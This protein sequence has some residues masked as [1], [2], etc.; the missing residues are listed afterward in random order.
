MLTDKKIMLKN[1][2]YKFLVQINILL[3]IMKMGCSEFDYHTGVNFKL[4]SK[5][6][7]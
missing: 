3:A 2:Y 1:N 6:I 4:G 5:N 7:F